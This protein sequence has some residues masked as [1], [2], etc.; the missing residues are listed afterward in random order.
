MRAGDVSNVLPGMFPDDWPRPIIANFVD[1]TARDLAEVIAP[2]PS[3]N[4]SA[5][6]MVSERAKKFTAK[7]TKIAHWYVQ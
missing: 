1:I 4:C 7:R 2:L 3:V 5:G 6:H